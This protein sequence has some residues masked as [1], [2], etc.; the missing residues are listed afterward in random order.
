M[1]LATRCTKCGTVFRVVQDQL[2]V[3]EGWVRCGQCSAVFN[4]L[5][6]LFDLERGPVAMDA[7]PGT[8]TAIPVEATTIELP[9]EAVASGAE[10]PS[11]ADAPDAEP[12]PDT[13]R[14]PGLVEAR[15]D[16]DAADEPATAAT[17]SD[18]GEAPAEHEASDDEATAVEPEFVRLAERRSQQ[19]SAKRRA[20]TGSVVAVL[21]V[22]M[23][24][25]GIH[26]FRDTLAARWPWSRAA[27]EA[28]CA[29]AACSIQA[30]RR[31]EDIA[32]ESSSLTRSTAA[33]Q[34]F[35]LAVTLRNRG[36]LP[37]AT[38]SLDL[39]LTDPSGQV[40]VR[41]VLAAPDFRASAAPLKPGAEASWQLVLSTRTERVTGY[42]IEAFYP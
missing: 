34:A 35:Q 39:S 6:G 10:P 22:T 26:Q 32:V 18:Q 11:R 40:V 29:A 7:E 37:L 31:I 30:P 38:P 24:L 27:L 28:G 1:S 41:R 3:S 19:T 33:A 2:K 17:E 12:P 8:E 25:Q 21:V 14:P 15:F 23:L 16:A 36:A 20:L 4:A 5:D 9:A 13:T 42:T